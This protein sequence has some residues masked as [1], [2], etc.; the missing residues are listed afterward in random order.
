MYSSSYEYIQDALQEDRF[1]EPQEDP[2][3]EEARREILTEANAAARHDILFICIHH[4]SGPRQAYDEEVR[5]RRCLLAHG[6]SSVTWE[7]L[8]DPL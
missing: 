1:Y 4:D 7:P 8:P 2:E 5:P 3:Q 6:D